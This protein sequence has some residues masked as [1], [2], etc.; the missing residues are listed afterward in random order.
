MTYKANYNELLLSIAELCPT[1]IC[2]QETFKKSSDKANTK[3][4]KFYDFIHDTGQRALGGV[5]ILI[6][7]NI[8]QN[9][10]NINTH[11]QTIAVSATLHK[12]FSICSLYIP[13][14][15]P[16][17][18]KELNNLIKQLLK[19]FILMGDFNSHNICGSKTTNKKPDL[20]KKSSIAKIYA[21]TI[22][23]LRPTLTQSRVHSLP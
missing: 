15:D 19:S 4:F 10:I 9:K 6:R 2:L 22:I 16:I 21:S 18:E 20:W 14:H 13:P 8:L 7:K 17:N 1:T 23:N 12:I 3:P 11:L 5:S